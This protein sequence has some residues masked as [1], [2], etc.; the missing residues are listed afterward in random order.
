MPKSRDEDRIKAPSGFYPDGKQSFTAT[1]EAPTMRFLSGLV[2]RRK[3]GA[4]PREIAAAINGSDCRDALWGPCL[5][6]W[7]SCDDASL[8][9]A[10]PT[11]NGFLETIKRAVRT[12]QTPTQDAVDR[13]LDRHGIEKSEAV[14]LAL[15]IA[16]PT[17][18][19]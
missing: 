4:S 11:S 12:D 16:R 8:W 10:M 17:S 1:S 19:P 18:A 14:A 9:Y 15:S 3:H 7:A 13:F 5:E 2:Q 6:E